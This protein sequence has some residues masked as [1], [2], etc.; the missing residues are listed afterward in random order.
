MHF[1]KFLVF[2]DHCNDLAESAKLPERSTFPS[3]AHPRTAAPVP[4]DVTVADNNRRNEIV[5][6]YP[7]AKTLLNLTPVQCCICETDDAEPL[8]VGEDFEYRTSP[9]TFLAMRCRSCG[10][11]YL[12][13]RPA[14]SDL[15]HIYPENYHAFQFTAEHYSFVYQ[16]RRRLEACRALSWCRYLDNDARIIDV[17]CGD[18]F[19][20]GL[21]REFGRP[22]WQLEGVD[23]SSR[24]V[25][26][27]TRSGLLVRQ[28]SVESLDLPEASYDMALLVQT[29]EHVGDPPG[30]LAA[31]RRLLKPGG[32]VVIVTDN[33]DSLDFK[34]FKGRYWGGYHFPRHWNL[35]NSRTLGALARK[36]D[37]EVESLT[38]AV[39]PVNWVY[40]IRNT[41]VDLGS[42]RWLTKRFSLES[43]VSLAFFTAF[44]ALHQ[45][46]GRGALLR[47]ILRRPAAGAH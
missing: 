17:G 38:T 19:H 40:S 45:L 5:R 8:G 46:A 35:F 44:D 21:L 11:V 25:A 30:V 39:S 26:M 41:L 22:T 16:V 3:V 32:K 29:I 27:A 31:V 33:T 7:V 23:N 20:L 18:G 13:P 12:S 10:L 6:D 28:G 9:D 15:D 24:A 2:M 4:G 42:P 1:L 43:P 34:L 47:A 37:L 36:V 14:L